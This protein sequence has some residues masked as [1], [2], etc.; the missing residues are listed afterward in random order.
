MPLT[1]GLSRQDEK[2]PAEASN[3]TLLLSQRAGGMA[4]ASTAANINTKPAAPCV[5]ANPS[6]SEI[7]NAVLPF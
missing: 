3:L 4:E 1:D 7:Q 5:P 2:K 6:S